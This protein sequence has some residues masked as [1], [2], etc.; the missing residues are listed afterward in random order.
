[1][2][3]TKVLYTEKPQRFALVAQ[4]EEHYAEDVGVVV[5]KATGSAK[6][7]VGLSVLV[8]KGLFH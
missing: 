6:L 1:M 2:P 7:A 4:M 3:K 5:S 8:M